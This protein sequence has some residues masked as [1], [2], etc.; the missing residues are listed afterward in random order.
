MIT[1]L[2]PGS[3]DPVTSGH[4]DIFKRTAKM[5]D[6]VIV[7]VFNNVSKQPLF[8]VE[9]RVDLLRRSTKDIPNL[10]VDAFDGLLPDY[11]HKNDIRVIVRG[12][13]D[14]NDFL[15]E[16]PRAMLLKN[17]APD[18]ESIFL[19]TTPGYY[20]VSSSAIRELVRFDGDIHGLVPPCVEKAI[21][22][23]LHPDNIGKK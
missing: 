20:H 10:T 13:R 18:I 22:L 14:A 5:F 1:A 6:R 16:F 15:Y 9:E 3:F 12:L 2:C 21:S 19:T 23:K 17:L 8:S 11:A 7:G 4:I